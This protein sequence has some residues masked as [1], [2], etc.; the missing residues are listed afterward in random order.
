MW[1]CW[2]IPYRDCVL[3]IKAILLDQVE[4][5]WQI[6]TMQT[7]PNEFLHSMV[8]VYHKSCHIFVMGFILLH[9]A[10]QKSTQ[11]RFLLAAHS[12][13]WH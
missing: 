1:H 13:S 6:F 3:S 10:F 4:I 2:S 5:K 9:F 12:V 7:P 8:I 11:F